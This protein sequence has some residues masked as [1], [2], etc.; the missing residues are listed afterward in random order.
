M[1]F[2]GV[3]LP[4]AHTASGTMIHQSLPCVKSNHMILTIDVAFGLGTIVY[5]KTDKEQLPR[6]VVAY[7]TKQN[8]TT[9]LTSAGPLFGEF[10]DFELSDTKDVLLTV[11]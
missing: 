1:L 11:E 5:Q 8:G 2:A 6:M 9:Y 10:F 3:V 4:S 7:C